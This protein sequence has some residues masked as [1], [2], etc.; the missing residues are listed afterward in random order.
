MRGVPLGF[1]V[2]KMKKAEERRTGRNCVKAGHKSTTRNAAN[3]QTKLKGTN[4]A[5]NLR[6][7]S[8]ECVSLANSSAD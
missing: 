4:W 3:K 2:E 8:K 1:C 5:G 6:G 7:S